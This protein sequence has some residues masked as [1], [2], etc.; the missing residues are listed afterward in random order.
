MQPYQF[1]KIYSQMEKEFGKIKVGQEDRHSMVLFSL[2]SN[3]LKIH[4]KN[5]AS[6][7]RRLREAIGLALFDAKSHY[8]NEEIPLDQFRNK[9]NEKLEIALLMAFDPFTNPAIYNA[10]TAA[11]N[12]D[13]NNLDCLH[14]YY[15]EPVKCMLRI[16]HSIDTWEKQLG[17]NGYFNF[18]E[19]TM[20][21]EIMGDEMTFSVLAFEQ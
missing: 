11:I 8:T 16:K 10:L 20:G 1:E 13:L 18:I 9:D 7:S 6:N 15:A 19:S 21:A 5:P 17:A 3:V 12:I 2:E 4:R 14:D